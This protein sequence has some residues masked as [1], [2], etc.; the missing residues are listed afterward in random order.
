MNGDELSFIGR[1]KLIKKWLPETRFG[2]PVDHDSAAENSQFI[3]SAQRGQDSRIVPMSRGVALLMAVM[4][5]SL[6]MLF[7]ADSIVTSQVDLR[8]AATQRDRI[9]AEFAAKS[10]FNLAT[11]LLSA[12]LAK[13]LTM[14]SVPALQ[15][16]GMGGLN[17]RLWELLNQLPPIGGEDVDMLQSF[18]QMFG[19]NAVMDESVLEDLK[20]IEG[21]F[22]V[23]VTDEQQKINVNYCAS[24]AREPCLAVR[25]ML[26][27]LFSCPAEKMFLSKKRITPIELAARIQ[28]WV[29]P[30]SRTETESGFSDESDP[31]QRRKRPFKSKNGPLD[32][33]DE[34]RMIEG[35]DDEVHA[36]FSPY[37]TAFPVWKK[38]EDRGKI[39]LNSASRELL[40]CLFQGA[41]P[42][43]FKKLAILLNERDTEFKDFGG[44]DRP[45]EQILAETFGYNKADGSSGNP[46]DPVNK[47]SWFSKTSQ[48]YKITVKATSGD[49]ERVLEAVVE[50]IV[51][52]AN[53]SGVNLSNRA[54]YRILH[55]RFF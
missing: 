6:M 10:G 29:D 34:L 19:L 39:N 53:V 27:A 3:T 55:W 46:A 9:R 51:P 38:R 7:A 45:V 20:S 44:Q 47:A 23:K 1:I 40:Q 32:S 12:D 42:E 4:M 24:G 21:S 17:I 2:F 48:T 31:Y 49:T 30:D 22:S 43:R 54:A 28:D 52:P 37:L 36:V 35:W 33:I 26:T 50:R 25:A 15:K 5:I 16:L 18:S 14:S 11:F 13:D 8:L 41:G